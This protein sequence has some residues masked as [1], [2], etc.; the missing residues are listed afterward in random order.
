MH[1]GC[2]QT[3]CESTKALTKQLPTALFIFGTRLV[4]RPL[5]ASYLFIVAQGLS[6]LFLEDVGNATEVVLDQYKFERRHYN[7]SAFDIC[8]C[9][10]VM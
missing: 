10:I 8:E 3:H 2:W 5:T 1:T 4:I 9:V 6:D 7:Y